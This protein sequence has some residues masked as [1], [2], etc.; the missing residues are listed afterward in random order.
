MKVIHLTAPIQLP[1]DGLGDNTPVVL[2]H[3]GL[4]RLAILRRLLDGAHIPDAGQRHV[5]RPG[6]RCGG[7]RQGVYLLHPLPQLLLVGDAEALLLVDDKQSQILELQIL[8]QQLV[9][10][11]QQVDA[12][13]LHPF[14]YLLDLFRGAEPGQHLHRHGERAEPV[15]GGGVMLLGQHSGGHQNG[16][17]LA[18][19]NAFHHSPQGH[20]RF[21]VA[22][23]AA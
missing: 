9:G 13:R 22:H 12:A 15:L 11:D 1:A 6:D 4:H 5:Q 21:A 3:V 23:V 19:Q 7:Q 8:V 18:V 2:Q 17:L 16:R 20:L 14:Q 10:A